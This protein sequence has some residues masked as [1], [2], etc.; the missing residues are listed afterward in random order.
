MNFAALILGFVLC[1]IGIVGYL[2]TQRQ[3]WTALIPSVFGVA[4]VGLG[5]AGGANTMPAVIASS[6][7]VFGIAA[8]GSGLI[9]YVRGYRT[10]Q[11][12]SKAAMS[13]SCLVFLAAMI[14][15]HLG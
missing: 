6:L 15:Q 2:A 3:S 9:K 5:F 10:P 1:G 8:T 13:A 4:F 11:A 14:A 12:L 7:A